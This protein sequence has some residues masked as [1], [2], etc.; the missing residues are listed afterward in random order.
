MKNFLTL[1]SV[2]AVMVIGHPWNRYSTTTNV[3]VLAGCLDEDAINY[4]FE[5]ITEAG[6]CLYDN[7]SSR[8]CEDPIVKWKG[9]WKPTAEFESQFAVFTYEECWD[10]WEV[11]IFDSLGMVLWQSNTPNEKWSGRNGS[12]YVDEGEYYIS[13]YGRTRGATKV[14]DILDDFN[15][16]L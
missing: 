10:E 7:E 8:R 4:C 11:T 6:E 14:I 12:K 15:L 2:F 9:R 1:L 3:E 13:I 16:S 5:C